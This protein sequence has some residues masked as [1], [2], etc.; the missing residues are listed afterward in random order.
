MDRKRKV[1][2]SLYD[3]SPLFTFN[4]SGLDSNFTKNSRSFNEKLCILLT[5]K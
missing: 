3:S 4:I 2:F 1:E 5:I